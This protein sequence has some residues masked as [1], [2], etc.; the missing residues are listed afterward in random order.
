MK[1][2]KTPKTG[3]LNKKLSRY[4]QAPF[5]QYAY[6]PGKGPK[7]EKRQDIP[8]FQFVKLSEE[9]W[10]NNE[11]YLY[12]IDLFNHAFYYEA[13]EVWEGLWHVTGHQTQEGDFLKMLIQ[14]SAYQL[15]IILS[16]ENPAQ[17]L[18]TRIQE[19]GTHLMFRNHPF[20]LGLPLKDL[21]EEWKI[22][23]SSQTSI[24]PLRL[25]Q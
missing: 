24:S 4:S 15:K 5:P 13:H 6:I 3:C 14:L 16:E 11:A 7:D 9:N 1:N 23:Q 12:G 8:Q 18:M 22:T 10:K 2:V 21:L 19:I 17:R 20:F 25:K